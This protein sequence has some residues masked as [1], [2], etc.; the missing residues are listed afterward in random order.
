VDVARLDKLE[1]DKFIDE[2]FRYADGAAVI[3]PVK[4]GNAVAT[5]F[6]LVDVPAGFETLD[7]LAQLPGDGDI[8]GLFPFAFPGGGL[9]GL[10]DADLVR[11]ALA[12]EPGGLR[13]S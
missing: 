4:G 6:H 10:L 13:R 12:G 11:Q 8:H 1:L 9:D 3:H 2:C 7:R 5:A